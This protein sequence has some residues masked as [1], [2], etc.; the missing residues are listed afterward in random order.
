MTDKKKIDEAAVL[1]VTN[2]EENGLT[3][4]T[5]FTADDTLALASLLKN[6]GLKSEHFPGPANLSVSNTVGSSS[7]GVSINGPDLRSI[8]HLLE[9][10]FKAVG[11]LESNVSDMSAGVP[12]EPVA[13]AGD[14]VDATIDDE[15]NLSLDT[16]IEEAGEE[17]TGI[18]DRKPVQPD[19]KYVPAR[20]GD[21]PLA[22]SQF[23][24][25]EQ[26]AIDCM[27]HLSGHD[28][29]GAT[30]I[31]DPYVKDVWPVTH[32]NGK[33]IVYLDQMDFEDIDESLEEAPSQKALKALA[34]HNRKE[35]D[36]HE[37]DSDMWHN[38][39]DELEKVQPLIDESE[40][41]EF[42]KN[43]K[44]QDRNSYDESIRKFFEPILANGAGPYDSG[45]PEETASEIMMDFS[46]SNYSWFNSDLD[47]SPET[48]SKTLASNKTFVDLAK[49]I[50]AKWGFDLNKTA[51]EWVAA[52]HEAANVDSIKQDEDEIMAFEENGQ[53]YVWDGL[54]AYGPMSKEE[55]EAGAED[56]KDK[57]AGRFANK[58][59]R[60]KDG[61]EE[62]VGPKGFKDYFREAAERNYVAPKPNVTTESLMDEFRLDELS[63]ATRSSYAAKAKASKDHHEKRASAL[64]DMTFDA[65]SRARA[66]LGSEKAVDRL[67]NARNR[68]D[69]IAWKREK[70]LDRVDGDF[71]K[72][73]FKARDMSKDGSAQHVNRNP[74][75]THSISD[76]YNDTTVSSFSNGHHIG[77]KTID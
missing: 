20:S 70:G 63:P 48:L 2:Q 53:W 36:K 40:L 29:T 75:G 9:P 45:T 26:G 1:T 57:T 50:Q 60:K 67:A 21:N 62:T 43:D 37:Q 27:K 55:A 68:E 34:D 47:A 38:W 69:R 16:E 44:H 13:D 17:Y 31:P 58:D 32:K 12:V 30:A 46:M 76:F 33:S 49:K 72:V 6:A 18:A 11:D 56:L 25:T 19:F 4:T 73:A 71:S 3:A 28:M 14:A 52:D 8:M 5:T 35:R 15:G 23:S 42:G 22:E 24:D 77:G 66:G 7:M 54:K 39:N 41:L 10:D 74:D 64:D 59:G 51:R 65:K 61:V